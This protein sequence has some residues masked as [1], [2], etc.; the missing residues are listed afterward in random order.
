MKMNKTASFAWTSYDHDV[1]FQHYLDMVYQDINK[2]HR[3]MPCSDRFVSEAHGEI[4]YSSIN[5]LLSECVFKEQ[6]VF[7]DLGSGQ[8]KMVLQVYLQ[9]AVQAVYG[10]ELLPDLHDK[11]MLAAKK[12][13]HDMGQLC[14]GRKL[15]FECG[16]FFKINFQMATI[17]FINSICFGQ[18]ILIKLGHIINTLPAIHTVITLRPMDNLKQLFLK[19]TVCVEGTW[20]SALCYIYQ[21]S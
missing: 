16:D 6:D 17:V 11:A 9:T 10:I 19:N 1:L 12:V 18:D 7:V 15:V 13:E 3:V 8:G 21:K 5:K 2:K 20:D 4:F 14:S